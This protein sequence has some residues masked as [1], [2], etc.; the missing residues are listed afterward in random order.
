MSHLLVA[1]LTSSLHLCTPQSLPQSPPKPAPTA[2]KL[3][4]K[5]FLP[6]DYRNIAFADLKALRDRGIWDELAVSVLKVAFEQMSKELGG[7]L[8][9]ID[10]LTMVAAMVESESGLQPFELRVLEGNKP[11]PLPPSV[12]GKRI[13][14]RAWELE[15]MGG[16]DVRR[17]GDEL[18][19]QPSPEVMVTGYAKWVEATL[20]GT[21]K[22]GLPCADLL[23]LLS[24]RADILAYTVLDLETPRMGE[25]IKAQVFPEVQWPEGDAPQFVSVRLL[26]SGDADDP[27]LGAEVVLRHKQSGVGQQASIDAIKAILKTWSEDPTKQVLRPLLKD[28]QVT[29]DRADVVLRSDLGRARHAV[30]TLATLVMPMFARAVPGEPAKIAAPAKK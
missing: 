21:K 2:A 28:A 18:L 6:D 23:S 5:S 7:P 14:G 13:T 17:R 11:L 19:V 12:V 1:A 3:T 27:H 22:D 8:D 4:V 25:M 20:L 9:D 30:G 15:Q 24:G 26:S 29:T 10:R 16:L